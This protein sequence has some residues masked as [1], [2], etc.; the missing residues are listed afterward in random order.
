MKFMTH[1]INGCKYDFFEGLSRWLNHKQWS[2][3]KLWRKHTPS[4]GD[5][6]S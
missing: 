6:F 1:L 2:E 5:R 3:L 4:R